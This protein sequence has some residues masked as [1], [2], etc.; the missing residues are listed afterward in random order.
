MSKQYEDN[1]WLNGNDETEATPASSNRGD[2][3]LEAEMA[4]AA[5]HDKQRSSGKGKMALY[6]VV[7][8]AIVGIIVGVSVGVTSS[9]SSSKSSPANTSSSGGGSGGGTVTPPNN[10]IA[11]VI[12]A[13]AYYGGT[14]FDDPESYQSKALGW[15]ATQT[16]PANHYPNL[17]MEE[18]AKQLYALACIFF[19]TYAQPNEWT[20]FH[21]KEGNA[22]PGW[23]VSQGWLMRPGEVCD[24]HGITCDDE[25]R[26]S[27]IQLD[28]NGLTGS[29]PA[30][31]TLLKDS[32]NTLDLYSN[33]VHNK[34]DAGNAWLGELTNLEYLFFGTTSFE[35]DGVPTHIGKLEKLKELDFSYTLYFGAIPEGMWGGL[36]QL[37][38]LAMDGNSYNS[39]L[40]S[41]LVSLPNLEFLYAT[42]SFLEGDLGFISQMP[43]IN[44]LWI[45]DNPGFAGTIPSSLSGADFLQGLSMTNCGLSGPIPTELGLMTDMIQ[46]WLYNNQL[47][48]T[49]PTEI[50]NMAALKIFDIQMNELTGEMPSEICS[51]RKPFGR[52]EELE[53][54]CDGEV[55]CDDSCCTCCGE[56]CIPAS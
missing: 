6:G 51:R 38:Y 15:V 21:F 45:D 48:G 30:E 35:Y 14:E 9:G 4:V 29:F 31:V 34:G 2:S 52:L 20:D 39:T 53:A 10:A 27:K 17:G 13:N 8:L 43:K 1:N 3:S 18:Q 54:D 46:M 41:D 47:T 24:W 16:L 49:I 7:V 56:S 28:T 25:N 11:D 40:P 36:T 19:S 32:L 37:N 22:I 26:V 42:Y 12:Y 5:D 23:H 33:L 55:T 50:G 44:E